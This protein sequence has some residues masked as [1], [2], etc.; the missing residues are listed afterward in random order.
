MVRLNSRSERL[1]MVRPKRRLRNSLLWG[2]LVRS[3]T[4]LTS[5][6]ADR[7]GVGEKARL[8]AGQVEPQAPYRNKRRYSVQV[9]ATGLGHVCAQRRRLTV[10]TERPSR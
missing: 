8:G 3:R 9:A 2:S 4:A 5:E 7:P 10:G 6:A 1:Q